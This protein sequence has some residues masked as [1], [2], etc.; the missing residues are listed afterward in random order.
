[1]GKRNR[2]Q[3]TKRRGNGDGC[4]CQKADGT[5]IA[6]ASFRRPDGKLKRV[7]RHATSREHARLRLAELIGTGGMSA[8]AHDRILLSDWLRQW[9]STL[10]EPTFAAS[11]IDSYTRAI[12]NHI[13]PH[14]GASYVS[15]VSL[16]KLDAWLRH[17]RTQT[18]ARSVQNAFVVLSMA[19]DCAVIRGLRTDNPLQQLKRP[20]APRKT[21]KPF[22]IEEA[23]LILANVTGT[24]LEPAYQLGLNH[25][26]RPGEIFALQWPDIN[27]NDQS[28]HIERQL[29]EVGG[30]IQIKQPK[31]EASIRTVTLTD[32][33]RDA[34]WRCRT[35]KRPWVFAARGGGLMRRSNFSN[36]HWRPLLRRLGLAHRGFHHCRHTAATLMLRAGIS[37]HVVAAILGHS[38]ASI[39]LDTYAHFLQPDAGDAANAMSKLIGKGVSHC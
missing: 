29:C 21:I 18:G 11:T 24:E 35:D 39:T 16:L 28:I 19:I 10:S 5:W 4:I 9:L 14:I 33:T 31:T 30:R 12:E 15:D 38:K 26:L 1:M 23:K 34:L 22:T 36:R 20:S 13:I 37:V 7:R 2:R 8:T 3:R 25:G 32:D 17:L 27:W 6:V